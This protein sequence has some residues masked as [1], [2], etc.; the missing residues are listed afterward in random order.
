MSTVTSQSSYEIPLTQKAWVFEE[1]NGPLQLRTDWP[2]TQ[3]KDLQPGQVLVRIAY[4]GVCH[5]DLHVWKGDWPSANKLP[6]VGGHE[7]AG[8]VAAIADNT[9]TDLKIG[10][11]VGIKW[12]ANSCLSCEECRK[13]Y[14]SVCKRAAVHGFTVDGSF[15]QWAVSYAAHVT[16]IPRN[17]PLELAAPICCAGVTVYKALKMIEGSPGENVVIPG[18][19]GGLGHLAVQFAHAMGYKVIGIDSGEE[20]RK[21]VKS[22]GA[23]VFVDYMKEDVVKSIVDTTNGGAH[24]SVC[25]ASGAA[26]YNQALEYL[27]PRGVLVAVGLPKDACVQ[28]NIFN[29]VVNEH[30]IIGSY[31]G[32]RQDSVEAL[33]MAARG[34][35]KTHFVVEPI[36]RLAETFDKMS[37]LTLA[38]RVV[39]D[40]A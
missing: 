17:L 7:G 35:V 10:D 39:L 14:E 16:P 6:L 4:S 36:D 3:P 34:A 33:D 5:T 26:A 19:G 1:N 9:Q 24:A 37:N 27:R 22:F 20:K 13:G 30:R 29:S 23:E 15:Q 8:Y 40:M 21:L 2:V 25:V 31:V 12:L 28:A 32:N 18:A 11:P 38:A